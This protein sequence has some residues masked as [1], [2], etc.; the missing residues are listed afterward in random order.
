MRRIIILFVITGIC[1]ISFSANAQ[2][3]VYDKSKHYQLR[4]MET[5]PWAFS[6]PGW[7]YSWWSKDVKILWGLINFGS[8]RLPGLGIHDNG[9]AGIGGGDKYVTRFGPNAQQRATMLLTA[10]QT[11]KKYEDITAKIEEVHKREL[12]NI[13]DRSFD[14]VYGEIKPVFAKLEVIFAKQMIEYRNLIGVDE[15]FNGFVLEEQK[16]KDSESRL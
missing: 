4:S 6:P 5:G 11:R 12:A 15:A 9:P 1:N 16:I 13:A 2:I 10:K 3:P 8:V 14:I 7:Y